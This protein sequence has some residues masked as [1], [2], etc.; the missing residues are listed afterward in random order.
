[1]LNEVDLKRYADEA[2]NWIKEY[3]EKTHA[4][5]VV[6]GNSGGKDSAV[7]LEVLK[8]EKDTAFNSAKEYKK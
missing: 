8:D 5:G 7:T 1:M 6:I 3:V 4:K 2:I